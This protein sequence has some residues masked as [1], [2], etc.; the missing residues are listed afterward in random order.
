MDTNQRRA[1]LA[2]AVLL[3]C[4]ASNM[5]LP[6]LCVGIGVAMQRCIPQEV[7]R[8]LSAGWDMLT[9]VLSRRG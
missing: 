1:C 4:G 2:G 6:V 8:A 9:C 3:V 7:D 5:F